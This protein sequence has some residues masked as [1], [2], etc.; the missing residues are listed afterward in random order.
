MTRPNNSFANHTLAAFVAKDDKV[1]HLTD[2][3]LTKAAS[4]ERINI[5]KAGIEAKGHK[6]H[7]VADKDAAFELVKSLIPD[8]A[9]VYTSHSTTL[10]EI[11]FMDHLKEAETAAVWK[12]I[13]AQVYAEKNPFLQNEVRRK[14]GSSADFFLTSMAAVTEAGELTHADQFGSKIGPVLHS[15]G[16]VIVVVSSNKIVKNLEEAWKRVTEVCAPLQ[17]A[18]TREVYKSDGSTIANYQVIHGANPMN[19]DRI[20][21]VLVKEALGF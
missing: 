18:Y 14:V 3:P 6:V 7:V 5:A 4:E 2:H 13:N 12:N 8:G 16:K 15:A 11:G 1:K 19:R 9:S 10:E 20:Q 21:V 17:A